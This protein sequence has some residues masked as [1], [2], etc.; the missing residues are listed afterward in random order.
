LNKTN[1]KNNFILIL[2]GCNVNETEPDL[3]LDQV[4]NALENLWS[5]SFK[6][7]PKHLSHNCITDFITP[8]K[9]KSGAKA[10]IQNL[11]LDNTV[12]DSDDPLL[13]SSLLANTNWFFIPNSLC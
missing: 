10:W 7:F 6:K 12:F 3:K 4:S 9:K 11:E 5:S 13:C 1:I 8:R 2:V